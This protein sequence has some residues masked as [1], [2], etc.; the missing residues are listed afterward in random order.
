MSKSE[1]EKGIETYEFTTS[2]KVIL[3][4]EELVSESENMAQAHAKIVSLEEEVKSIKSDF[5]ARIDAERAHLNMAANLVRNKYEYRSVG[6][7]CIKDFAK[8]SV[9]ES[10]LDTQEIITD[11]KMR[12]DERQGALDFEG[13]Q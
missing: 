12:D 5:K 2:L 1:K 8:G 10:R 7:H 3:S 11:R 13:T 6:C 9:V 4:P